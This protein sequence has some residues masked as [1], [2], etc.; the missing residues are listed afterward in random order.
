MFFNQDSML[1]RLIAMKAALNAAIT[2]DTATGNPLTFVTDKAKPLKS[3]LIPFTPVQSGTGDPSPD[4]VRPISGWT[5]LNV[6]HFPENALTIR[7][8]ESQTSNGITFTPIREENVTLAVNVKGKNTGNN[9]F[10]NLNYIN[11]T[12][13]SIPPGTYTVYGAVS[14]VRFQVFCVIDGVE[15][16]LL[17]SGQNTFT[18]PEG[19]TASWIRLKVDSTDDIDVTIYPVMLHENESFSA[20]TVT[21]PALGKN[22]LDKSKLID[23]KIWWKG[24]QTSGYASNCCTPLIPIKPNTSYKRMGGTGNQGY[25]SW[26]DSE[27]NY[28]S[29]ENF[30][31]N[32]SV[33]SPENAYYIG[34]SLSI[35]AK[36]EAMLYENTGGAVSYEPFT[37]T[38]YGGTLD[39]VS[40]V[41]T[42]EWGIV[43]LKERS[44][45]K[46][47]A[48]TFALNIDKDKYGGI[49]SDYFKPVKRNPSADGEIGFYDNGANYAS[50]IYIY[51]SSVSEA[52]D[53]NNWLGELEYSPEV[54]YRLATPQTI[55]LTPTEITALVGN[56]TIWSDTNGSNTAVYLKKG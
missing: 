29:Q 41:L 34:M 10:Y 48:H 24:V 46:Y 2:E 42:V 28:I 26:F 30:S 8:S 11:A 6:W 5:G 55:Q 19:V 12:T 39:V 38:I 32:A 22:L 43:K 44:F 47:G 9:T 23:G 18:V 49:Y 54:A 37:N 40:G 7:R 20:Y 51:N 35:D 13:I 4:N 3:L 56:N 52:T 21:F 15:T 53:F 50:Q 14:G 25:V 45:Y 31:V 36:N 1:L 33:T 27:Q 16:S 17:P